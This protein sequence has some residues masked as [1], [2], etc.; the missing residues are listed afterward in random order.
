MATS[1]EVILL[2]KNHGESNEKPISLLEIHNLKNKKRKFWRAMI[3][4]ILKE[5][6]I[7]KNENCEFNEQKGYKRFAK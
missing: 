6:G 1:L 4:Y 3:T 7:I 2:I 5:D